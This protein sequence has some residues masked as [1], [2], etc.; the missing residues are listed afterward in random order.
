MQFR[1][2]AGWSIGVA[3]EGRSTG[4]PRGKAGSIERSPLGSFE[5]SKVGTQRFPGEAAFLWF[6]SSEAESTRGV[7]HPAAPATRYYSTR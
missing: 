6:P 3:G 4:E 5:E 2:M 7:S 1:R